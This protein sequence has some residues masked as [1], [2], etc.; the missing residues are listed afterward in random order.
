M[1]RE[2]KKNPA[3]GKM[4]SALKKKLAAKAKAKPAAGKAK[5]KAG[6]VKPKAKAKTVVENLAIACGLAP[7]E[8][9]PVQVNDEV[10]CVDDA[11]FASCGQEGIVEELCDGGYVKVQLKTGVMKTILEAD[12]VRSKDFVK[13]QTRIPWTSLQDAEKL[14]LLSGAGLHYVDTLLEAPDRLEKVLNEVKGKEKMCHRVEVIHLWGKLLEWGL[15][16]GGKACVLPSCA[17]GMEHEAFLEAWLV[18]DFPPP[19]GQHMV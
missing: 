8:L 11:D 10:R 16:R 17:A 19:I 6:A 12:V 7:V 2:A 3:V 4:A 9:R 1:Q 5:A 13:K 15:C 14:R 18:V